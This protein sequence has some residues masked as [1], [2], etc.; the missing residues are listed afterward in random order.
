MRRAAEKSLSAMRDRCERIESQLETECLARR[1]C[2]DSGEREI[3][4][5]RIACARFSVR[6]QRAHQ[7]WRLAR[8]AGRPSCPLTS[9]RSCPCSYVTGHSL[10]A[11][12]LS[13]LESD[14]VQCSLSF[15]RALHSGG[16]K[17]TRRDVGGGTLVQP[18][19]NCRDAGI[20]ARLYA[21]KSD[22]NDPWQQKLAKAP[23]LLSRR[24]SES[25]AFTAVSFANIN[26]FIVNDNFANIVKV[27]VDP[28]SQC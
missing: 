8:T 23:T 2:S 28:Y 22:P 5:E 24:M 12:A 18:N 3:E 26:K 17:Y 13:K 27:S 1:R 15:T 10:H 25:H 6:M 20:L 9:R 7:P 16:M 19:M 11:K 21:A 14:R 4:R